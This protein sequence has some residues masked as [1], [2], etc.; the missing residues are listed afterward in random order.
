MLHD[1]RHEIGM[2]LH[3]LHSVLCDLERLQHRYPALLADDRDD[4]MA[5]LRSLTALCNRTLQTELAQ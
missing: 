5:A 1:P 2:T 3:S 4:L